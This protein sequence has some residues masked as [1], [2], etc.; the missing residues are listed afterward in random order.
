[1]EIP[2]FN[3]WVNSS[4]RF[5]CDVDVIRTDGEQ[6]RIYGCSFSYNTN[7]TPRVSKGWYMV[8]DYFFVDRVIGYSNF[9]EVA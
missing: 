9:R 6:Q 7:G 3:E 8:Q 1:M 4:T 2:S 5:L